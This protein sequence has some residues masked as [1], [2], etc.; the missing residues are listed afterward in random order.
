V[1]PC[2]VPGMIPAWDPVNDLA[3]TPRSA[4]AMASSDIEMRS[5][6]VSSMSISRGGGSGDTRLARA[7]RPSVGSPTADPAH[8]AVVPGERGG[9]HALGDTPDARRV[10]DRGATVLL[11]DQ[12][13]EVPC[14]SCWA[15]GSSLPTPP[16]GDARPQPDR[17][18][19]RWKLTTH[20]AARSGSSPLMPSR[21]VVW[22]RRD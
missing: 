5:P 13:H 10:A 19:E 15:G 16:G 12:G 9:D 2:R 8:H 18:T 14:G 7:I 20:P 1:L 17:D 3:V 11:D 4:M 6:A 22:F 21:A